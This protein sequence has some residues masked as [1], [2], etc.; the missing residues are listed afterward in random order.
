LPLYGGLTGVVFCHHRVSIFL[1]MKTMKMMEILEMHQGDM[2]KSR[3]KTKIIIAMLI[4]AVVMIAGF[5]YW[6]DGNDEKTDQTVPATTSVADN[7][8]EKEIM[9]A[10]KTREIMDAQKIAAM[11]AVSGK[12]VSDTVTQRPDYV[13]EVEWKVLQNVSKQ[14]PD[15]KKQLTDL[16]N[17]LLFNK[18]RAAWLS[19]GENTAQRKQL[20]RQLL[21]MIPGQLEIEAID[22]ETAKEMETKLTADLR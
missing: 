10:Q 20:A 15:N 12:T 5:L 8:H 13:S 17:K 4:S 2:N 21:D 6:Y 9:G 3:P 1:K 18:K 16:V 19:A 14:Q 7:T 11:A 22:S